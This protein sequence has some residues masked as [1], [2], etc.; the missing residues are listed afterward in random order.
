MFMI[1]PVSNT[2]VLKHFDDVTVNTIN[3]V[4]NFH[5]YFLAG[6]DNTDPKLWLTNILT[7]LPLKLYSKVFFEQTKSE[8]TH[9]FH[10]V[11]IVNRKV[12]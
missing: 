8:F 6:T 3:T 7:M 12:L 2:V 10:W 1:I 9:T 5:R 11:L 4:I